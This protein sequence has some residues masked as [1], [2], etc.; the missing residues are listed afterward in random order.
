MRL[1][2]TFVALLV[3]GSG[4]VT[5]AWENL[6]QAG[7]GRLIDS[8]AGVA[9]VAVAAMSLVLLCRIVYRVSRSTSP[10]SS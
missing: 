10:G 8:V 7:D 4:A 5:F 2:A 9:A 1:L 3:V 6:M